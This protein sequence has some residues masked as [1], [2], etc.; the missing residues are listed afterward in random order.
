[1]I[2][3]TVP[4]VSELVAAGRR[5]AWLTTR[6]AEPA[7]RALAAAASGLVVVP[8]PPEPV[9]FAAS[10]YATLHAA[11]RRGFDTIVIEAPPLEE[12]WRAVADRLARAAT[13]PAAG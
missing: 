6:T 7:V 12:G 1:V 9:A 10:L 8:M 13:P 2:A 3:D 4:R 5:V 11:D